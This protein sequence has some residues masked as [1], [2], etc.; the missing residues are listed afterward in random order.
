MWIWSPLALALTQTPT[1]LT[2][3]VAPGADVDYSDA[4]LAGVVLTADGAGLAG[5]RVDFFVSN[6]EHGISYTPGSLLATGSDG[7]AGPLRI[8]F[9][10]G[11]YGVDHLYAADPDG[12][13]YQLVA[14]YGGDASHA[15]SHV[16]VELRL[17]REP[18]VVQ[19]LPEHAA[20]LGDLLQIFATLLDE[21]GDAEESGSG[22]TGRV[23]K[24]IAGASIYFYCDLNGDDDWGD[25]DEELGMATTNGDGVAVL[26]FD[27]TPVGGLPRAGLHVG[28]LR[29]EFAGDDRY[30]HAAGVGDLRLEA[31]AV[32]AERTRL[33]AAPPGAPADGYSRV[34]LEATLVD[35]FGNAL[36]PDDEAHA[37]FFT[38]SA[39]TL[40]ESVQRDPATGRYR[41][42]LEAP[43]AAATA[44]V[45]VSVDGVAGPGIE[46]AF[47]AGA[48]GCRGAAPPAGALPAA[49]ALLLAAV[50]RRRDP[51]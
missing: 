32:A 24:R 1:A 15:T 20:A 4:L 9:V 18:V 6:G 49:I 30:K 35:R 48:C 46:V 38:A 41:Q 5:Q 37:V 39:G 10:D 36:G 3:T 29:A 47:A 19:L 42:E 21:N 43:V 44:A 17:H 8:R 50:R 22:T 28:A 13:A 12:V 2:L 16:G 23:A 26:A 11:A 33:T 31:A 34:A 25:P 45:G 14:S 27:T 40:L 51:A 7:R